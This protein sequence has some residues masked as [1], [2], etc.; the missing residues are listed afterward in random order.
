VITKKID[1]PGVPRAMA[2]VN[3]GSKLFV[4]SGEVQNGNISI[5]DVSNSKLIKTIKTDFPITDLVGSPDGKYIYVNSKTNSGEKEFFLINSSTGNVIKRIKNTI[6]EGIIGASPTGEIF[7]ADKGE[8]EI[9]VFNSHCEKKKLT[10]LSSI[11]D[12]NFSQNGQYCFVSSGKELL[13][14]SLSDLRI[15]KTF[16]IS[17]DIAGTAL[18]PEGMIL[19]YLPNENRVSIYDPINPQG[20]QWKEYKVNPTVEFA[21]LVRNVEYSQASIVRLNDLKNKEYIGSKVDTK[22]LVD[23]AMRLLFQVDIEIR[24]SMDKILCIP[25]ASGF[26]WI[27]LKK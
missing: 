26:L 21:T 19:C 8:N 4:R 25:K 1:I 18:S 15:Q 3:L 5:I 24:G 6:P 16:S 12:I 9:S 23:G 20:T 7:I 27:G 13:Y 2:F 10:N 14:I 17:A 22:F 11:R